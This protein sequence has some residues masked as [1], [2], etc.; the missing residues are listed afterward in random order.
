LA[1]G[2]DRAPHPAVRRQLAA[3]RSCLTSGRISSNVVLPTEVMIRL[4]SFDHLQLRAPATMVAV[5]VL[6]SQSTVCSSGHL[7]DIAAMR[8]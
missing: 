1:A 5:A 6:A 3:N 8:P 4:R 2:S 7:W